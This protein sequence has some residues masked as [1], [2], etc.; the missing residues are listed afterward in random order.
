MEACWPTRSTL[1]PTRW[2]LAANH[3]R[4]QLRGLE[5]FLEVVL[6]IHLRLTRH[7]KNI[8]RVRLR[9][10]FHVITLTLARRDEISRNHTRAAA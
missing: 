2:L 1:V 10:C 3:G 9:A 6:I 4:T 8:R 7:G 5:S